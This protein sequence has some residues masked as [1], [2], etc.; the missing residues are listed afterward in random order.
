MSINDNL[1]QYQK[2]QNAILEHFI[3]DN[4]YSKMKS[5]PSRRDRILG[6]ELFITSTCNKKCTYCYLQK[7]EDKLYPPEI[8]NIDTIL[9]N[10]K[11]L[12]NHLSN[13]NDGK[14]NKLDL[15]SGE[16][17][18]TKLSKDIFDILIEYSPK[19]HFDAIIIPSN[20]SFIRNDE[21]TDLIKEY[22]EKFK[23]IETR[24][25]FS[26]SSDGLI[27]DSTTRPYNTA[28]TMDLS[29]FY[30]K[31]WAFAEEYDFCFHP[32]VDAHTIDQ[33]SDNLQWWIDECEKRGHSLLD[34]VMTLEVRNPNSWND[35]TITSY[36]KFLKQ[37]TEYTINLF[38]KDLVRFLKETFELRP[39]HDSPLKRCTYF[40]WG[41]RSSTRASCSITQSLCIR[42]GDLMICPCHRLAYPKLNYGKY[43]VNDNEEIVGIEANNIPNLI[44]HYITGSGG[45]LKCDSCVFSKY[46]IKG[47][48]GAQ[49]EDSK[50]SLYPIQSVCELEKAKILYVLHNILALVETYN[51]QLD[52]TLSKEVQTIRADYEKLK[53][54]EPEVYE[55]WIPIVQTLSLKV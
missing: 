17:W 23:N 45:Y 28:D 22:I 35:E 49:F 16:I 7:H 32:M 11:I 55:K 42:L 34:K 13:Y 4:I 52:E 2:E 27:I 37:I 54:E 15:F 44:S 26:C 24:L 19:V 21:Q 40:P 50:E 25:V 47:C 38:D 33:W 3:F 5:K 29:E 18:G 31:L 30:Q 46:C 51:I 9:S 36:L 14:F 48:Q 41:V 20:C 1:I 10:L 8:R 53:K 39:F 43:I 6:L 12:L